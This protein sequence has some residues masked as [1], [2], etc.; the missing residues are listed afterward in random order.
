MLPSIYLFQ[1]RRESQEQFFAMHKAW[2]TE[3]KGKDDADSPVCQ[4]WREAMGKA[5][6]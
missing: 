6:L 4:R 3:G 5:E 2:C 1:A